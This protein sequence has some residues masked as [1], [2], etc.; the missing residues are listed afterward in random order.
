[1]ISSLMSS[2]HSSRIIKQ[3]SSQEKHWV[4]AG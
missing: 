2:L 3:G 1:M 4:L